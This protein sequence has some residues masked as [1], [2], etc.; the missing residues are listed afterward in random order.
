MVDTCKPAKNE[1]EKK[2]SNNNNEIAATTTKKTPP[3]VLLWVYDVNTAGR[4]AVWDNKQV[5]FECGGVYRFTSPYARQVSNF[6]IYLQR[7]M[8]SYSYSHFVTLSFGVV[9][10][11]YHVRNI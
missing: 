8:L 9:C 2:I 11:F 7:F 4:I 10:A 1:G 5:K 6:I 3:T